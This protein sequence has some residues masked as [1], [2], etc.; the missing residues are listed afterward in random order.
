[1]GGESES[2]VCG[3][4]REGVHRLRMMCWNVC[5]WKRKERGEETASYLGEFNMRTK[6]IDFYRPDL[7]A[8]VGGLGERM[9]RWWK[10]ID[11]LDISP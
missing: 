4:L 7:L 9:K 2:R 3:S 11:G 10:A 6:V 8:V 1:M 5:G